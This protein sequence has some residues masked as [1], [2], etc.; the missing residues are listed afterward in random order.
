MLDNRSG[1][2]AHEGHDELLI[3]RLYGDDLDV[4]ERELARGMVADCADC[5]ALLA[6]MGAIAAANREFVA[7]RRSRDFT[8]TE[9][10][11]AR[12]SRPRV[13]G[14]REVF[15]PRRIAALG[16]RRSLGAGMATLGIA[17]IVMVSMLGSVAPA[18][19][20]QA[21]RAAYQPE[22]NGAGQGAFQSAKAGQISDGG[23]ST[24]TTAS[25]P[26]AVVSPSQAEVVSSNN[27]SNESG[28]FGPSVSAGTGTTGTTNTTGGS[29]GFSGDTR[30]PDSNDNRSIVFAALAV[31]V[32]AGLALLGGPV[33]L[34]RLSARR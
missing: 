14:L 4:A 29:E 30:R 15:D 5:S 13:I 31:L 9:A 21:D 27:Y 17:G 33:V 25:A 18:A 19:I 16:L 3:A 20:Q 11:A 22:A 24:A 28:T 2:Q 23:A 10:D 6:D 1:R 34:R 12:L 26:L 7:P 32:L 8:L